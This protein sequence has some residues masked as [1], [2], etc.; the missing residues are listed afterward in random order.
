MF[1]P[2]TE[3]EHSLFLGD[4]GMGKTYASMAM[5]EMLDPNFQWTE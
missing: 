2:I 5:A 4:V 1:I 3:T